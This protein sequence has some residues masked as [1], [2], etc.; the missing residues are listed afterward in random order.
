VFVEGDLRNTNGLYVL[1][2]SDNSSATGFSG[3][4]PNGASAQ[5]NGLEYFTDFPNGGYDLAVVVQGGSSGS[6]TNFGT[7]YVFSYTSGGALLDE[8][9]LTGG[10]A[11]LVAAVP[12][13]IRGV[14]STLE[15]G[16]VTGD[17][18]NNGIE[19]GI[20]RQWLLYT[21]TSGGSVQVVALN[22]N[23]TFNNWFNSTIPENGLATGTDIGPT[24]NPTNAGVL[25]SLTAPDFGW[26]TLPAELSVFRAD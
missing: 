17:A 19:I 8:S 16:E 11:S 9:L 26:L 10:T 7:V 6:P 20:P 5:S 3:A 23:G 13:T 18:A 12:G 21:G 14:T 25:T 1:I 4:A 22:C 15:L 24:N 2:D